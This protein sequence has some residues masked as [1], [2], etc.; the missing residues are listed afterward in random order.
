[1]SEFDQVAQEVSHVV[2]VVTQA[3]QAGSAEPLTEIKALLQGALARLESHHALLNTIVTKLS[4]VGVHLE[5][6][7]ETQPAAE[8]DAPPATG[9]AQ[10]APA[11]Q[12]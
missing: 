6:M 5:P 9:D 10:T 11:G 3:A 1:M 4:E 8:G 7:P 2:Q 12:Q